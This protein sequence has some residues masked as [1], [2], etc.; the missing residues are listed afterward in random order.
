MSRPYTLRTEIEFQLGFSL[1]DR[2]HFSTPA[3]YIY[4]QDRRRKRG[5]RGGRR[6]RGRRSKRDRMEGRKEGR[7]REREKRKK[8]ER[9]MEEKREREKGRKKKKERGKERKERALYP[10]WNDSRYSWKISLRG[11]RI[12]FKSQSVK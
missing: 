8:E 4:Y 3:F 9:K 12:F 10:P 6:G 7:E 1:V 11:R 2:L 5:R